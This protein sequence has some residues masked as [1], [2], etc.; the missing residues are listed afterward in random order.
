TTTTT[1]SQAPSATV[2]A[3][4]K[5]ATKVTAATTATST[6]TTSWLVPASTRTTAPAASSTTT[7]VTTASGSAFIGKQYEPGRYRVV[8]GTNAPNNRPLGV[9]PG[10]K[11]PGGYP[12]WIVEG[13]KYNGQI[14][15]LDFAGPT[16]E[17]TGMITFQGGSWCCKAPTPCSPGD[18]PD[19]DGRPCT[20]T[21]ARTT[22]MYP[23]LTQRVEEPNPADPDYPFVY[24]L[25]ADFDITAG[26]GL[27]LGGPSSE[28]A[29]E[30]PP[31][32]NCSKI[33]RIS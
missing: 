3:K 24:Y 33:V 25:H 9:T 21:P 29:G 15:L 8:L 28:L 32:T 12:D 31:N 30:C 1:T 11:P 4:T 16:Y 18:P 5:P 23:Y 26:L 14:I 6:S 7:T 10:T 17:H 2:P 19:A 20:R 27:S 13:L 22:G